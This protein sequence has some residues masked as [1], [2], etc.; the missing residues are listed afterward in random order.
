[1]K[2][3]GD[4]CFIGNN[5]LSTY[6]TKNLNLISTYKDQLLFSSLHHTVQ[7]SVITSASNLEMESGEPSLAQS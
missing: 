4:A 2:E 3:Q 6:A 5:E 1:M 7:N